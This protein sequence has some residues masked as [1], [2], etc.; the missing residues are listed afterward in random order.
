MADHVAPPRPD[1]FAPG[2]EPAPL[3]AIPPL[4]RVGAGSASTFHVAVTNTADEAR[5]LLVLAV[6]VDQ[7]WLPGP[8]RTRVLAPGETEQVA[9]AHRPDRRHAA[10]R[11]PARRHRAV[12][13]ARHRSRLP[14]RP[15]ASARPRWW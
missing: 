7:A 15:P 1:G 12:G 2:P 4:L 6:G 8:V 13:G 3:V 14:G 9:A 11:V 10:G 5:E